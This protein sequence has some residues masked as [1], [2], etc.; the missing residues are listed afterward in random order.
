MSMQNHNEILFQGGKSHRKLNYFYPYF[1]NDKFPCSKIPILCIPLVW[2]EY[3]STKIWHMKGEKS[4][5]RAIGAW[6]KKKKRVKSRAGMIK[7]L[8]KNF[9]QAT[10]ICQPP[11]SII[12][13]KKNK[14]QKTK[15]AHALLAI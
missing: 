4:Q 3:K 10:C 2:K 7:A 12:M 8:I 6:G 11:E 15:E 13:I 9:P 1:K 5:I 14:K